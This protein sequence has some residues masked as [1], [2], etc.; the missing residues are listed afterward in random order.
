MPCSLYSHITPCPCVLLTCHGAWHCMY[1]DFLDVLCIV[2]PVPN[3]LMTGPCLRLPC[4]FLSLPYMCG[5]RL[6]CH[7][8]SIAGLASKCIPCQYHCVGN[9]NALQP[10]SMS[11][12][13]LYSNLPELALPVLS[14][15]VMLVPAH[16]CIGTETHVTELRVTGGH[17][18]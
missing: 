15:P 18:K 12:P 6:P 13:F 17:V 2:P 5:P 9:G 10:M 14:C 11:C 7:C 4:L 3:K 8:M 16:A 1:A